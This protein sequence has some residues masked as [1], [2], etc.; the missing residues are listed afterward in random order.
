LQDSKVAYSKRGIAQMVS[1]Y[2]T[3]S[4]IHYVVR[5]SCLLQRRCGHTAGHPKLLQLKTLLQIQQ[6]ASL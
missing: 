2:T 1:N 4:V 6:H 3:H 5:N